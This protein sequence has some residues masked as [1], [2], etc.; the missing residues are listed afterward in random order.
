[1]SKPNEVIKAVIIGC[2]VIAEFHYN[3]LTALDSAEV[4]GVYGNIKEQCEDFAKKHGIKA[5][6]SLEEVYQSDC[7]VVTICTPSG[8]HAELAISAMQN[9]KHVIV[10][11][12]LAITA[13][14]C[15]RIIKTEK[16]TGK[17]CAPISQL[18]YSDSV[19]KVKDVVESNGLGQLTL[20]SIYMKFFRSKTY[21]AGSWRGTKNMDGGG[22]LMNQGI[23]GIDILRFICGDIKS[24][25][26]RVAT[27]VHDIEVEDTA[28]ASLEFKNG[29]LGVIEGAT[30]V[31]PGYPRRLELCGS[32][33]SLA[34][35]EDAIVR[36]DA[37][38]LDLEIG[39]NDAENFK[40]P[41][42]FSYEGHKRQ[43][44]N[45]INTILGKEKLDYTCEDATK[46]VELILS[47]YESSNSGKRIEL[48]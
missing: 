22:A 37:P 6:N 47:V 19:R 3:A 11:K 4:I 17:V 15:H 33:G 39:F 29:A 1:M 12:P 42:A 34:M 24:V 40:D 32:V 13:E 26:A 27:L 31:T 45:V 10:E 36:V 7:D 44:N 2:G 48:K 21:Y 16:E 23:H 18:R 38:N 14:D 5:F 35:E 8:T 46:T 25:Q 30:S 43:F 28:V 41:T 20:C 9:G